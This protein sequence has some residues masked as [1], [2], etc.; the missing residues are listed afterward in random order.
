MGLIESLQSSVSLRCMP[1]DLIANPSL[2]INVLSKQLTKKH[3]ILNQVY[4]KTQELC[5]KVPKDICKDIVADVSF[6][7]DGAIVHQDNKNVIITGEALVCLIS[8][9]ASNN[10]LYI[11][12]GRMKVDQGSVAPKTNEVGKW[13]DGSD[14]FVEEVN[15]Q[16]SQLA[17]K[18]NSTK[19]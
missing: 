7:S 10:K 13:I 3:F 1:H 18:R 11:Y 16:G 8:N 19:L 6:I 12:D 5:L 14:I 15:N 2:I 9:I 4:T 17:N